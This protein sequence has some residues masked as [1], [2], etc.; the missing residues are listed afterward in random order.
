M[1][2]STVKGKGI[3]LVSYRRVDGLFHRLIMTPDHVSFS[4]RLVE[5]DPSLLPPLLVDHKLEYHRQHT[6]I[7]SY[8][9][10]AARTN[11]HECSIRIHPCA[12]GA[13]WPQVPRL[14]VRIGLSCRG[15]LR[16]RRCAED[17]SVSAIARVRH[18]SARVV[19]VLFAMGHA[20]FCQLKSVSL[21]IGTFVCACKLW[22]RAAKVR[23]LE[24]ESV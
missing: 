17:D 20:P 12:Q 11:T 15:T 23:S 19:L 6:P 10:Q 9:Y 3:D 8:A 2:R 24:A 14:T 13:S 4:P 22:I 21:V 1:D 16:T 7:R 5:N 18:R